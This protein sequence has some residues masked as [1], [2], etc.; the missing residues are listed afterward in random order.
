MDDL[1]GRETVYLRSSGVAPSTF[2]RTSSIRLESLSRDMSSLGFR[3]PKT[4]F[5]AVSTFPMTSLHPRWRSHQLKVR[6]LRFVSKSLPY[7][8]S[9]LSSSWFSRLIVGSC[10][11]CE[12]KETTLER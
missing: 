6:N 11:G 10:S 9:S 7:V 1:E 3:G 12:A 2:R 4:S 8:C 5:T